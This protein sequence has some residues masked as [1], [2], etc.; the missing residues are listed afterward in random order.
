[1]AM[2]QERAATDAANFTAENQF[3]LADSLKC[4]CSSKELVRQAE[5]NQRMEEVNLDAS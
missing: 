3:E 2:L 4:E 5:L 1:M